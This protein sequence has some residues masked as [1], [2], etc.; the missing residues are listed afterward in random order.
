MMETVTAFVA[1]I[2]FQTWDDCVQY[3]HQNNLYTEHTADQCVKIL[4]YR[5]AGVLRPRA[6][7]TKK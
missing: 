4:A 5:P 2:T 3:A 7:P 6:R 1:L